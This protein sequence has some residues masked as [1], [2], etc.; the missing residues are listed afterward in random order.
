MGTFGTP[1]REMMNATDADAL[2]LKC[3]VCPFQGIEPSAEKCPQCG[4][5]LAPL[6]RIRGLAA[7]FY[8]EALQDYGS[9]DVAAA[10]AKVNASVAIDA[11][12]PQARVLLGKLLWRQ[13]HFKAALDQ[14]EAVSKSDPLRQD[15]D[16]LVS[17]AW[18][19]MQSRRRQRLVTAAVPA[20]I[21]VVVVAGALLIA[22]RTGRTMTARTSALRHEVGEARLAT[23]RLSDSLAQRRMHEELRGREVALERSQRV[24]ADRTVDSLR[25]DGRHADSVIVDLQG[26]LAT[27]ESLL[28]ELQQRERKIGNALAPLV[29]S[30]SS[31]AFEIATEDTAELVCRQIALLVER[32]VPADVRVLR[33]SLEFMRRDSLRLALAVAD[34]TRARTSQTAAARRRLAVLTTRLSG[35][36]SAYTR[37]AAQWDSAY[38]ILFRAEEHK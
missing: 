12:F 3:P 8:N 23:T 16:R 24:L 13:G 37:R 38:R 2:K 9:G 18:N 7:R 28:T 4:T 17:T 6:Q 1:G 30:N 15:A 20:A 14:W 29:A 10:V 36:R 34:T 27:R 32:A 19:E 22:A 5:D 21:L 33:D 25:A 26:R 35:L 31:E 11:N